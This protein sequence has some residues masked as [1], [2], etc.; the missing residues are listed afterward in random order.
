MFTEFTVTESAE[1]PYFNTFELGFLAWKERY[2]RHT[3]WL[4]SI[5]NSVI[6]GHDA[7]IV[8]RAI[9]DQWN[10][11]FNQNATS[12]SS[13][14]QGLLDSLPTGSSQ[15]FDQDLLDNLTPPPMPSIP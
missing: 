12:T 10:S 9:S 2:A 14:N 4:N 8:E 15:G 3:P 13:I 5:R 11:Q 1:T 6:R 7:T